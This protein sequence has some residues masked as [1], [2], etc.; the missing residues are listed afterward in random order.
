M[1]AADAFNIGSSHLT[2][3]STELERPVAVQDTTS[4]PPH[5]DSFNSLDS[6]FREGRE[7]DNAK[8]LSKMDG[9]E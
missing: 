4:I 7:G 8:T 1:C 3:G 9:F 5:N 2:V 6:H